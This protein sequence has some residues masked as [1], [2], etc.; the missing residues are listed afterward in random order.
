[1]ALPLAKNAGVLEMT[2]QRGKMI[3]VNIIFFSV[4]CKSMPPVYAQNIKIQD[5]CG[6]NAYYQETGSA[7][8]FKGHV[9]ECGAKREDT[10]KSKFTKYYIDSILPDFQSYGSRPDS[11]RI[12]SGMKLIMPWSRAHHQFS[13]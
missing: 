7:V 9:E 4:F 8:A 12:T 13:M 3:F 2:N 10:F 1:M 11:S 6:L 5:V